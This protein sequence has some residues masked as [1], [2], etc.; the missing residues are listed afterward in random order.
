[1]IDHLLNGVLPIFSIGALGFFLGKKQVFSFEAAMVL[2]KFVMLIG[3]PS[4][5]LLLLSRAPI[6]EF[7]V[8]MLSGYFFTEVVLYLTGFLIAKFIFRRETKEAAL[9]G[10]CIALTNHILFVLPIAEVL[11]GE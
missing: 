1:M 4:L 5:I 7:N 9:I 2:N 11:F 6:S 10:L 3:M 8:Q